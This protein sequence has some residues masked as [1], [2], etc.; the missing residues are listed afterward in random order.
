MDSSDSYETLRSWY[1]ARLRKS[2]IETESSATWT[3]KGLIAADRE[4]VEKL[5]AEKTAADKNKERQAKHT[6]KRTLLSWLGVKKQIDELKTNF[7]EVSE[8]ENLIA[9]YALEL[10]A[11]LDAEGKIVAISPTC[12][13][14]LGY[15]PPSLCGRALAQFVFQEDLDKLTNTLVRA[16]HVL[17]PA[18]LDVLIKTESGEHRHFHW[19]IEWSENSQL[20]FCTASDITVEKQLEQTK[21]E[22]LSI[23]S[24]DLKAPVASLRSYLDVLS[25]GAYGDL[26][27]KGKRMLLYAQESLNQMNRLTDDLL[28]LDKLECGKMRLDLR[29]LLVDDLTER[30]RRSVQQYAETHKIH[31]EARPSQ[32]LQIVGDINRLTQ[33]LVNLLSNAIKFS[34]PGA[35]VEIQSFEFNDEVELQVIDHGRGIPEAYQSIVFE[36]YKQLSGLEQSEKKGSGLGLAIAKGFVEAHHGKIGLRSKEGEGCTFWLR[37]R[38]A[39]QAETNEFTEAVVTDKSEP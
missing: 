36:R 18:E 9:D 20:F 19:T 28:D 30:A 16:R 21:A 5:I 6:I 7:A 37:L 22:F 38:K 27:E 12:Y 26:S 17:Q 3:P 29:N 39:T 8:R 23:V 10:I 2:A 13:Q 35:T 25:T 14:K 4:L 34:P 15:A 1:L 24:H 11:A 32:R 33:V 31:I